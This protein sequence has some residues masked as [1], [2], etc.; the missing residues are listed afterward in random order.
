MIKN[1]IRPLAAFFTL[2][3]GLALLTAC[4]GTLPGGSDSVNKNF[5]SSPDELKAIVPTLQPGMSK[6]EVFARLGRIETHFKRLSRDEIVGAIFGGRDSGVPAS[7][8]APEGNNA[9]LESLSGYEMTYRAIKRKHGLSSPI[10]IQTDETGFDYT[11]RLVF[12][13]DIL[14]QHPLLSGGTV[15]S[16]DSKTIFDYL[17]PGTV[18]GQVTE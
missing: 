17:N 6:A 4:V 18:L 3:L 13:N 12:R 11:L 9:F 16:D 2:Y 15:K 14:F 1:R 7:F 8:R 5:Y 10:R